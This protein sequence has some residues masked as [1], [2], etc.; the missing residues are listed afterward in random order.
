MGVD[1]SLPSFSFPFA[2]VLLEG[3]VH[4]LVMQVGKAG[5]AASSSGWLCG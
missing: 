5:L 3:E 1:L 4:G 2:S